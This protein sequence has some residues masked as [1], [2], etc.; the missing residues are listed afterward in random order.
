MRQE[1]IRFNNTGKPRVPQK[2]LAR[3]GRP[4]AQLLTCSPAPSGV[5]P[6][7][8]YAMTAKNSDSHKCVAHLTVVDLVEAGEQCD[9]CDAFD[10]ECGG[11]DYGEHAFD[12]TELRSAEFVGGQHALRGLE[13]V[14]H[15]QCDQGG[16]RHD[17]KHPS[18]RRR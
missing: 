17:A 1:R 7:L 16:E 12:F 11:D 18:A 3:I 15:G 13:M 10:D 8:L 2:A 5:K 6:A 14:V 9:E 4:T